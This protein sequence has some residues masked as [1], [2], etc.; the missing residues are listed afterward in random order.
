MLFQILANFFPV[1]GAFF[2]YVRLPFLFILAI[3]GL[4]WIFTLKA[5]GSIDIA[6]H[7]ILPGPSP[8]PL[9]GNLM[10][11]TGKHP[12]S[13]I[14]GCMSKHVKIDCNLFNLPLQNPTIWFPKG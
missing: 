2:P 5:R 4:A 12:N 8:L 11:F 13:M 14:E 9:V 10:E 3:I 1:L 7:R 6:K